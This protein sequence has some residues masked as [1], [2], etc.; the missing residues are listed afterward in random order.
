MWELKERNSG[1]WSVCMHPNLETK[2]SIL[3]FKLKN[4]NET[5]DN[6]MS[7]LFKIINRVKSKVVTYD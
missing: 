3:R 6:T 4:N 1:L 2:E 5:I 7:R